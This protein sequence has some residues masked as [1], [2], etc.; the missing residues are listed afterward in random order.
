MQRRPRTIERTNERPNENVEKITFDCFR[1][2]QFSRFRFFDVVVFSTFRALSFVVRR[3][4]FIVRRSSFVVRRSSFVVRRSSFVVRRSSF[5]LRPSSFV[6]RPS[7]FVLRPSSFVLRPSSFILR[8]SSFFLHP[9]SFVAV[10]VHP[11]SFALHRRRGSSL[12][13]CALVRSSLPFLSLCR[14]HL[15]CS[16]LLP[17]LLVIVII[18]WSMCCRSVAYS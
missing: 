18:R 11:S 15:L 7:S 6:V 16:M 13:R 10:V 9:S 17:S 8:P 5:V 14:R 12:F 3:S 1:F 2:L 4:S